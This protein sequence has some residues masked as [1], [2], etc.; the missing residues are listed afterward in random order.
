[1][2]GGVKLNDQ[3]L[4]TYGYDY[5]NRLSNR[6]LTTPSGNYVTEYTYTQ[7][8]TYTETSTL[9]ATV[10]N[11]NDTLEY[12]YD[13]S[14]NIT[15]VTKNDMYTESYTYD[16]LNQLIKVNGVTV[17]TYTYGNTN[18]KDQLTGFNGGTITY[19]KYFD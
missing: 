8:D 19:D 11:G 4:L 1:M 12:R 3:N 2:I 6:T 15:S 17:K 14:G 9:V 5:L 18:W 7:G 13:E 10:K 16:A